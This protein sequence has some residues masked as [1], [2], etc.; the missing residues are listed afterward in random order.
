MHS[1]QRV[2]QYGDMIAVA[3]VGQVP[4]VTVEFFAVFSRLEFALL[5][6][7]YSGG[8]DGESAWVTWDRFGRD[9][10]PSFFK[11]MSTD[12]AIAVLFEE[13]ARKLV[14]QPNGDC[15]F[16]DSPV[17]EDAVD[18]ILQVRRIRNNLFHGSK[19]YFRER[20][21]QLVHAAVKVLRHL[22]ET[23]D[24]EE[25][26]WKVRAAWGYADVGDQ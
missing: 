12:Q 13:P 3:D 23:L 18:L 6:S 1:D 24:K 7:G 14:R 25:K 5:A 9:V 2:V 15:V 4:S 11:E 8:E 22:L 17:P 16:Q 26:T 19:I 20:D 21:A 10:H